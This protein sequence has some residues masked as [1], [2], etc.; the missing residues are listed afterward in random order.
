MNKTPAQKKQEIENLLK[1]GK[2]PS[3]NALSKSIEWVKTFLS[4]QK[5]DSQKEWKSSL[6]SLIPSV[7]PIES[8]P[9]T[10]KPSVSSIVPVPTITKPSQ[11]NEI[12]KLARELNYF[13][14]RYIEVY[15][16]NEIAKKFP[17]S[18]IV[19]KAERLPELAEK[20]GEIKEKLG[21]S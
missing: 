8:K 7:K 21:I 6:S 9:L 19:S 10:V 3:V 5:S 4:N 14:A 1:S 16:F 12:L 20:I 2:Y 11:E 15:N 18:G 13:Q 17:Q